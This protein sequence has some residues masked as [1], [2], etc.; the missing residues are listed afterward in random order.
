[1]KSS[2]T[3]NGL[4]WTAAMLSCFTMVISPVAMGAEAE[5]MSRRQ[6]ESYLIEFGLSRKETLGQ[7]WDKSKFYA[8]ANLYADIQKYVNENRNLNMPEV[9]L[10]SSKATDGS[11]VP[12][13]QMFHGGKTYTVQLFGE[14]KRYIRINGVDLTE[15]DLIRLRPAL[16]RLEASDINIKNE[17][18]KLRQNQSLRSESTAGA[19]I[20]AEYT[21]D[22]ARFKGF[23]R[24]TP[25]M[26]RSMTKTERAGYIVK[27]RLLW[28][29]AQRVNL[30][31]RMPASLK[32]TK[33]VKDQS[34]LEKIYQAFVGDEA[35]AVDTAPRRASRRAPVR[36]GSATP[37]VSAGDAAAAVV[38]DGSVTA[39]D[40]E[41]TRP[42]VGVTT[43]TPDGTA[44]VRAN[45]PRCIV[46]GYVGGYGNVTNRG[47]RLARPGCSIDAA[48]ELY[49][50][51]TADGVRTD[52][53]DYVI[54]AN[55]NC[56]RT[57]GARSVACNPIIYGYPNGREACV[58]R[59]EEEFQT[60]T[61]FTSRPNPDRSCDAKSRLTTTDSIIA[62]DPNR[63]YSEAALNREAQIQAVEANQRLGTEDFALTKTYISGVLTKRDSALAQ[64][65]SQENPQWTLA[66]DNELVRIQTEF[67]YQIREAITTCEAKFAG[68]Q[69]NR[70]VDP[71]QRLACDQLHRRWLFT[72]RFIEK[73]RTNG[74]APGSQYVWKFATGADGKKESS[75]S[76]SGPTQSALEN[77]R[78]VADQ[79]L[80]QCDAVA[81][82]P[83]AAVSPAP[84]VA[85]APAP[86]PGPT[87]TLA[88][89][90]DQA[91]T[92]VGFGESCPQ[93]PAPPPVI[94]PTEP[95]V[96]GTPVVPPAT[97]PNGNPVSDTPGGPV[98]R[99]QCPIN[100]AIS[101]PVGQNLVCQP[102]G[103]TCSR[104]Q[105]IEGFNYETCRCDN[106]NEPRTKDG[107]LTCERKNNTGLIIAG[108]G[109]AALA[110]FLLLRRH[111]DDPKCAPGTTMN[112]GTKTCSCSAVAC[113]L[114]LND[115]NSA[116]C[117]CT[118]K[119]VVPPVTCPN[120]AQT[121]VGGVC[122]CT[123]A[124]LC[125]GNQQVY[126]YE[127]CQCTNKPE[128]PTCPNGSVA[129][130]GLITKCDK[131][132]DGSYIPAAPAT[133]PAPPSEGGGGQPTCTDPSGCNGGVPTGR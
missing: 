104:P 57:S 73:I 85:P 67:E 126:N 49:R 124:G 86:A 95:P 116:S 26:W 53:L 70:E 43:A 12:T 79:K 87:P 48:I 61:H 30:L 68:P 119:T 118:P 47:S 121:N 96:S 111:K 58:D 25:K 106:G 69:A 83:P 20:A 56:V 110:A 77:R 52:R 15:A 123:T 36:P 60:A 122:Q 10:T 129:P 89:T 90:G 101:V 130:E 114:T 32:K 100:P 2:Q 72:E 9:S 113:D 19:K 81:T 40:A 107:R 74:C 3:M 38:T 31:N 42:I 93:S 91:R 45:A 17:A 14:K 59:D 37:V 65:F 97:C 71:N 24:V 51:S 11:E 94:P 125:T 13:L 41:I 108:V 18:N 64:A 34:L 16:E 63:P 62:F 112:P 120:A 131:C 50:T 8:P 28:D 98:T 6:V 117:V 78:A 115:Y 92:R 132:S 7:F 23:P 4:K 103:V 27:M 84:A 33:P 5:R 44:T 127:T 1:M 80:C 102:V 105:G 109:L 128:P 22:F 133:C 54:E 46:A 75:H 39:P 66:L 55:A 29:D 88:A 99:C 35:F 21:R 76:A 82:P